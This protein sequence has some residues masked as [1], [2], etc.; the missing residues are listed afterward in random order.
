MSPDSQGRIAFVSPQNW[1]SK[2]LHKYPSTSMLNRVRTCVNIIHQA[3][4][5]LKADTGNICKNYWIDFAACFLR[6]SN[7]KVE[8]F[9]LFEEI[10]LQ[11]SGMSFLPAE[12]FWRQSVWRGSLVC[13]GKITQSCIWTF[14]RWKVCG[15]L[16]TTSGTSSQHPNHVTFK[17]QDPNFVFACFC[18]LTNLCPFVAG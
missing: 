14:H 12:T 7:H 10:I 11:E 4:C 2:S 17:V 1:N 18:Q 16:W 5:L 13:P 9:H 8:L 6:P 3:Q 15:S